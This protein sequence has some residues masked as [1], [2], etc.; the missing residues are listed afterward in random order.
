[1]FVTTFVQLNQQINGRVMPLVTA[2]PHRGVTLVH[3]D[4]IS[5][6]AKVSGVVPQQ[7][8]GMCTRPMGVSLADRW[9]ADGATNSYT[10]F[11]L[12]VW[13]NFTYFAENYGRT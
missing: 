2:C 4:N 11:Y 1:M 10:A 8:V 13:K 6:S 9:C 3:N 5:S 12:P 7:S